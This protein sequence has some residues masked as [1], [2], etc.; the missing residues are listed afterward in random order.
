MLNVVVISIL[1][2]ISQSFYL[3]RRPQQLWTVRNYRRLRESWNNEVAD[4]QD[5]LRRKEPPAHRLESVLRYP[6]PTAQRDKMTD[7]PDYFL[8]GLTRAVL[9]PA[10][11]LLSMAGTETLGELI[12]TERQTTVNTLLDTLQVCQY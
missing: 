12:I 3:D 5:E 11:V 1:L 9:A 8:S 7:L 10:E 6:A 4:R 2:N